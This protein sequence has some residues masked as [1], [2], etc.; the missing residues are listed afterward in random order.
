MNQHKE[1]VKNIHG[2]FAW[3]DG[4][5]FGHFLF[6][7]FLWPSSILSLLRALCVYHFVMHGLC[8]QILNGYI[9]V[10][11]IHIYIYICKSFLVVMPKM[12]QHL[13]RESINLQLEPFSPFF[14]LAFWVWRS[15]WS[16]AELVYLCCTICK[17]FYR[18]FPSTFLYYRP[19]SGT[20]KQWI[21]LHFGLISV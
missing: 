8:A 17:S 15:R 19:Q 16:H 20:W 9:N 12:Y 2:K 7:H 14:I 11:S 13:V 5:R 3:G 10:H 6:C 18:N 21:T 1:N 4:F